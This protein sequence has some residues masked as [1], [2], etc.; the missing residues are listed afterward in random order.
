MTTI[1]KAALLPTHTGPIYVDFPHSQCGKNG[2]FRGRQFQPQTPPAYE[3]STCD[4]EGLTVREELK[5]K[6][7]DKRPD[8]ER[9]ATTKTDEKKKSQRTEA[10][11]QAASSIRAVDQDVASKLEA[12][13]L[14]HRAEMQRRKKARRSTMRQGISCADGKRDGRP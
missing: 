6:D 12:L 14:D 5:D 9:K 11:G 3:P 13:F 10:E 2:S 1:T 4:Q 8:A 7:K